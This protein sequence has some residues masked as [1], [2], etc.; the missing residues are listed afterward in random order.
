MSTALWA[1]FGVYLLLLIAIGIYF[2]FKDDATLPQEYLIADRKVGPWPMAF[3]QIASMASGWTFFAWVGIGFTLGFF[4]LWWAFITVS[5]Y[6]FLYRYFGPKFRR[7]S[8]EL[9]SITMVDHLSKF[10]RDHGDSTAGAIRLV[11]GISVLIFLTAYVGAQIIAVGDAAD[12]G[13]GIDYTAAIVLGGL[14]VALYTGLG[15]FN[16]SVWTDFIQG[17][18]M[19]LLAFALPVALIGALGGWGEFAARATTEY[20]NLVAL[21]GGMEGMDLLIMMAVFGTFAIAAIGQP[22][23]IVRFQAIESEKVLSKAMVIAMFVSATRMTLP[24]IIGV[25][26]RVLYESPDVL[27]AANPENAAMFAIVD[28]FPAWLAGV[29]LAGVVSAILSTCDSMLL[30]LTSDAIRIYEEYINPDTSERGKVMMSRG[31]VV[32]VSLL[33]IVLAYFRPGTLFDIILFAFVGLGVSLG[34]PLVFLLF[35]ERMT[36]TAALVGILVGLGSNIVHAFYVAPDLYPI[37]TWPVT[38]VAIVAVALLSGR[39]RQ[40]PEPAGVAAED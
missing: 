33:G 5:L 12:I 14:A 28:L 21:S 4:G 8:E 29:M 3:S 18:L 2:F 15:G 23:S 9:D 24:L 38:I 39:G 30:L 13:L 40:V 37:F 11:G 16:A 32:L 36:G 26:A 17:L 20:P 27:P 19:V 6:F 35:W 34:L 25:S 10:Y 7:Q 31:L 22:H 1:T